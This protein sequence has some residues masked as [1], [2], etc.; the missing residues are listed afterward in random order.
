MVI[1]V[2]QMKHWANFAISKKY[3]FEL[4]NMGN[5][6]GYLVVGKANLNTNQEAQSDFQMTPSRFRVL[7]I[8]PHTLTIANGVLSSGPSTHAYVINAWLTSYEEK[9]N[10]QTK[11]PVGQYIFIMRQCTRALYGRS[12]FIV[13][14]TVLFY[15]LWI[16]LSFQLS[17]IRGSHPYNWWHN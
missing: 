8:P 6:W 15:I 7:S 3:F 14:Y 4:I 12:T 1:W 10:K 11:Y 9:A 2:L 17:S 13:M 5:I 16:Q